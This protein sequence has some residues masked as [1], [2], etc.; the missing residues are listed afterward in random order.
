MHCRFRLLGELPGKAAQFDAGQVE[1]AL[2]NLV[3]NAREAGGPE[4]EVTLAVTSGDDGAVTFE[5]CDRGRGM[6]DDELQQALRPFHSSKEGGAGLGLPLAVEIVDAHRGSLRLARRQ[7]GGTR[8][9][10]KLP[11]R[12]LRSKEERTD[13]VEG[14]PHDA[15]RSV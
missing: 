10:C 7:G 6:S 15:S 4:E 9:V 1:Q 2:I 13:V 11:G 5:V 3:K 12:G 14:S 8:V